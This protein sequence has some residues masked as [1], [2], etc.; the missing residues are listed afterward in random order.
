MLVAALVAAGC[1]APLGPGYTVERQR[2]EVAFVSAPQPHVEVRATW[3]VKNTGDRALSAV[4][5]R[6]PD[7]KL[8]GR[9]G[10]R[11]ESGGSDL[12]PAQMGTGD[13][14]SLAF[15]SPLAVKAKQEIAVS[16]ELGG[17]PGEGA[18]V[19]VRESGFVLPPGDWAPALLPPKGSFARVGEPPKRWE[20]TVRVPS[21][22]RVHASGRKRGQKREADAAVL[23][24]EQQWD[25]LPPFVAAGAYQEESIAAAGTQ[26]IF[27]THQPIPP[28]LP[29]RAAEV[30]AQTAGFYDQEFGA[31]EKFE[32]G[33]RRIWIIECPSGGVCWPVP[34]AALP[35]AELSTPEFW[36]SDVWMLNRELARTWLDFR[37]HPDWDA[38]PYP[39]GALAN[40]A[41]D[42]AAMARGGTR[43]QVVNEILL[44][45]EGL[46]KIEP[47]RAIAGIR[48]S[49]PVSER[50]YAEWKSEL[51]FLA[52]GDAVG[53]E[54]VSSAIRHLLRT[55]AGGSWRAAD[56]RSALEMETGRDLAGV[57]RVWLTETAVPK[58]FRDQYQSDRNFRR[59]SL[60]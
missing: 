33:E 25:G 59:P 21:G 19:V 47:A 51:F 28:G 27:W 14:V 46:E 10:L 22:F 49:D 36:T 1:T 55:Y 52:L 4:E 57:F 7:A 34:G 29:Q 30:V 3:R 2:I 16:Y 39:M 18:G 38:E 45:L 23:R 37:V 54:N 48:L 13:A 9:S 17:I 24:W 32:T 8:T 56:L 31:P 6:L 41:A 42:L 40:Y 50:R 35:G 15:P 60:K 58:D 44:Q 12:T 20:M 11:F 26:I 53:D 43:S 5:L